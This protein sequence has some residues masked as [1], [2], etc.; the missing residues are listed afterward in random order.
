VLGQARELDA[1]CAA[2]DLQLALHVLPRQ[3]SLTEMVGTRLKP[4]IEAGGLK[5]EGERFV[6]VDADG[7]ENF[8]LTCQAATAFSAA[9]LDA[10]ALT[11]LTFSLD[12]P[13]VADGN[14]AFDQM[15]G[16]ARLCAETLGGQLVDAQHKPLADA[17]IAAIRAR[18]GEL[19][20]RMTQAGIPAGGMRA[21]R[22][23]S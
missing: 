7:A 19:Q 11:G 9:R 10:Q 8:A 13:R 3:G 23:F 17:T 2:V 6:A 16:F 1:F 5:L 12:V 18:I 14:A 4:A 21:L 15:I 20:A 22:L